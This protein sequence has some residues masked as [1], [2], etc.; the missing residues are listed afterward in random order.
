M[1]QLN[2]KST[3]VLG[4][5]IA[6]AEATPSL[7]IGSQSENDMFEDMEI[8]WSGILWLCPGFVCY[9]SLRFDRMQNS[10]VISSVLS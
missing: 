5:T 9:L 10:T 2:V 1:Q 3:T 4:T 8:G 7:L 6:N